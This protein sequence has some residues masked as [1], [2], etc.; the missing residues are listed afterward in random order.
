[1]YNFFSLSFFSLLFS[2]NSHS[3]RRIS[4]YKS[5]C[6]STQRERERE[7]RTKQDER[8]IKT[9]KPRT[10]IKEKKHQRPFNS[11]WLLFK[12]KFPGNQKRS[13]MIVSPPG[14]QELYSGSPRNTHGSTTRFALGGAL[15]SGCATC[16]RSDLA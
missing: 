2:I 10:K 7:G 5:I 15:L 16:A 11:P 9:T 8:I 13:R 12:R 3:V 6:K 14:L 1:M 4:L